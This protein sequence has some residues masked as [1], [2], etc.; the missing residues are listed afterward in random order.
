MSDTAL[1]FGNY[2]FTLSEA[3]RNGSDQES[4][5]RIESFRIRW[6]GERGSNEEASDAAQRPLSSI[7]MESG[8]LGGNH[9]FSGLGL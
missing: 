1:A 8:R 2:S 7:L 4:L 9:V 6:F 5:P 3:K